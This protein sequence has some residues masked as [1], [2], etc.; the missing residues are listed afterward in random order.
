M[1]DEYYTGKSPRKWTFEEIDELLQDSGM[2]SEAEFEPEPIS[3]VISKPEPVDPRP[4]YNEEIE[5]KIK[6]TKVEKSSVDGATRAFTALE[7]DKYRRSPSSLRLSGSD[8]I[9]DTWDR[10]PC[11]P[12]L[13]G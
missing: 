5:H 2:T 13:T 11:H 4:T 7:S 12:V 3:K 1:Y 6:T 9:R 8:N 10:N